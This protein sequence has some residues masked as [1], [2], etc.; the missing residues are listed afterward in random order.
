MTADMHSVRSM[1]LHATR[2]GSHV[3]DY[4]AAF[5]GVKAAIVAKFYGP[6]HS[7][8]YSPSVQFTLME[9]AKEVIA[10]CAFPR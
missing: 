3:K 1:L 5:A 2:Y 8:V 9:M 6:A 7:G 4:D 10:T